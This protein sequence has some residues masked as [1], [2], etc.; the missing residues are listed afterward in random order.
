MYDEP[1]L[2][3]RVDK[4]ETIVGDFMIRTGTALNR[5]SKEMREFKNEMRDE[6]TA[7]KNEMS[8]FKN[9]MSDFKD[10]VRLDRKAMNKQWG[11]LANRM[12]T[13]TEDIIVPAVRPAVKRYFNQEL[14]DFMVKRKRKIKELNLEGEFDV[15]AVSEDKVFVVEAKSSPDESYLKK[16]ADRMENFGKLFPEYGDKQQVPIFASL[17]FEPDI[18]ELAGSMNIYVMAYR[19]WDYMDILNF[20]AVQLT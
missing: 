1:L 12:G 18:T 11:D 8:E 13:F 7:F 2:E 14:T 16:F 3:E 6:M 4:L 17:R 10:E 5:L 19:E 9:E 15:V 20:E